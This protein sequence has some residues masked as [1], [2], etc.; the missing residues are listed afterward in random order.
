MHPLQELA[1]FAPTSA[2]IEQE[3]RHGT[4]RGVAISLREHVEQN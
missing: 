4:W 3:A 1:H 2:L